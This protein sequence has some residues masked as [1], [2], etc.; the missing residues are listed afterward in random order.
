MI[1]DCHGHYTT[2]PP[3]HTAWRDAQRAAFEAGEA[4]PAYPE[5]SDDAIRETIEG[6]QLRLMSERGID[7]TIFSPRA[8]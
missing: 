1:I 3:E 6:G 7:L 4:A 5:I 8:S 2:A